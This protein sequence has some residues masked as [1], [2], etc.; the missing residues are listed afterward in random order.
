MYKVQEGYHS[1]HIEEKGDEQ[2]FSSL[3]LI[4]EFESYQEAESYVISLIDEKPQ[5][6]YICSR[7]ILMARSVNSSFDA[8]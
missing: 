5:N 1:P 8:P 4:Q 3:S 2:D 7:P 6:Y